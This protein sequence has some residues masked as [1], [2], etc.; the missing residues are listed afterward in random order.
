MPRSYDVS[1][2][3]PW[4]PSDVHRERA[5]R[6]VRAR[7]A[8]AHPAWEV[9][10]G[11][12]GVP[13]C[14]AAAV[15]DGLTRASGDVLVV[16]DADVWSDNLA[17]A[18]AVLAAGV[19]WVIPHRLVHRLTEDSTALVLAGSDPAGLPTD[20]RPYIGWPGGGLVV[21]RRE[22]WQ[23]APL[24]PRF[25]GWGLEDSSWAHCLDVL[26]GPHER[27]DADL[28]HLWHPPQARLSRRVGNTESEQLWQRY[29]RSRGR[30]DR[31]AQLVAEGRTAWP[32]SP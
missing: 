19:P 26:I 7:Y 24:D 17:T 29:R 10:E 13:W 23:I 4:H 14:K 27:L 5:W 25:C 22:A 8:A 12:G 9:V 20:E 21:I 32:A 6:W 3:V 11:V 15:A 31:M 18:V 28:Y 1:V 2:V 16:A 30:P